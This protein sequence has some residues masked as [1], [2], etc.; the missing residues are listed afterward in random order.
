MSRLVKEKKYGGY[1]QTTMSGKR[2]LIVAIVDVV[3]LTV[4][5][6]GQQMIETLLLNIL[7]Y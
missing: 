7:N 1:V 2:S 4:L 3:V 6:K 5:A